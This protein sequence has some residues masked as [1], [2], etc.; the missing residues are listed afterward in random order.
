MLNSNSSNEHW[1]DPKERIE[2]Y[3]NYQ[4]FFDLNLDHLHDLLEKNQKLRSEF[5]VI[6]YDD[7]KGSLINSYCRYIMPLPMI[8]E[9]RALPYYSKYRN[10]HSLIDFLRPFY[11]IPSEVVSFKFPIYYGEDRETGTFPIIRKSRKADDKKSILYD[12]R[13]LRYNTPCI[14][15]NNSDHNW[16]LKKNDVVWRGATTGQ[17]TR[18]GFVKKYFD[19]YDIGFSNVKQKPHLSSYLK[20]KLSI[21][22]QLKYK[23]IVSLQGNDL[24]SN[25]RWVLLSNSVPIMPKPLWVGWTMENKLVPNVHYLELNNDLSN[26]E[27]LLDWAEINDK[28]CQEI[29]NNGKLYVSQFLDRQYDDKIRMLLLEE[30][31]SRVNII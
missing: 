31:A 26:L 7:Y 28:A 18:E 1:L 21:S 12:L 3:L 20:Q 25:I 17:E 2:Y 13:S 6:S 11:N 15:V 8:R 27:E 29:A 30:Y 19:Q 10:L 14:E 16:N 23:F 22:Q 4:S 24:A 5:K 9:L